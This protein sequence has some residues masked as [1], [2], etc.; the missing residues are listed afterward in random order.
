M[1][2]LEHVNPLDRWN[3]TPYDDALREHFH[4]VANYLKS[5][6]GIGGAKQPQHHTMFDLYENDDVP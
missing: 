6:G 1:V 4:D 3:G 5:C 2:G